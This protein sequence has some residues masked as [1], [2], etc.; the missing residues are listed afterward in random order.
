[1]RVFSRRAPSRSNTTSTYFEIDEGDEPIARDQRG[2][3]LPVPCTT[4]TVA[5]AVT[6]TGIKSLW[7]E[8]G[9]GSVYVIIPHEFGHAVQA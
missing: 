5:V 9:D 8:M 4:D 6:G 3:P 2:V 1:M 7:S